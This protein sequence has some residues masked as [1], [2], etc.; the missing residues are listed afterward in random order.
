[1]EHPFF[2]IGQE[3]DTDGEED[4]GIDETIYP[5]DFVESGTINDDVLHETLVGPLVRK[6]TLYDAWYGDILFQI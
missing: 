4:D 5:S 6:E 3:L 2:Y 1:M